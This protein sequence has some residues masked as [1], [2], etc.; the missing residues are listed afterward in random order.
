MQRFEKIVESRRRGH[1]VEPR[2][3]MLSASVALSQLRGQIEIVL[4]QRKFAVGK[5]CLPAEV[6]NLS[7]RVLRTV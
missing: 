4:G 2:N 1:L 3:R 5:G 7:L 6:D